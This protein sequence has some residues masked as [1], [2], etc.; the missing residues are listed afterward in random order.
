[1]V[2]VGDRAPSGTS[3]ATTTRRRAAAGSPA[4]SRSDADAARLSAA[5]SSSSMSSETYHSRS[6]GVTAYA[7]SGAEPTSP[8]RCAAA[9]PERVRGTYTRM[10]GPLS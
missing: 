3:T 5:Y 9:S 8:A 7:V 10:A 4:I 2:R 1:M 6:A